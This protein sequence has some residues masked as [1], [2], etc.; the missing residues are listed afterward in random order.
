MPSCQLLHAYS[1]GMITSLI[2]PRDAHWGACI[3]V[4]EGGHSG[5]VSAVAASPRGHWIT[6]GSFDHGVRTWNAESGD[7]HNAM[8]DHSGDVTSLCI[9]PDSRF[10]A[11]GSQNGEIYVWNVATG[12]PIHELHRSS[13][14]VQITSVRAVTYSPDAGTIAAGSQFIR[15]IYANCVNSVAYSGDGSRLVVGTSEGTLCM[16]GTTYSSDGKTFDG[17]IGDVWTVVF[18][19]D[20]RTAAS[21]SADWTI[22]LWNTD[23]AECVRVL[24][25]HTGEVNS[26]CVSA[27]SNIIASGSTDCTVRLWDAQSGEALNVLQNHTNWVFSVAF[28]HDGTRLLSGSSDNTV[29]I[30]DLQALSA[31]PESMGHSSAVRCVALSDDLKYV[32]SCGEDGAIILWD[33]RRPKALQRKVDCAQGIIYRVAF[34]PDGTM[35]AAGSHSSINIWYLPDFTLRTTIKIK[36]KG[37]EWVDKLAFS[38]DSSKVYADFDSGTHPAIWSCETG[39]LLEYESND[40]DKRAIRFREDNGWITDRQTEKKLCWIADSKRRTFYSSPAETSRGCYYA[41]G[42]LTGKVTVLDLSA[43]V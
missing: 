8:F 12:A 21:G 5:A 11:S 13:D 19:Q 37:K 4:I 10:I 43:L 31:G 42:S 34:S 39:E 32:A 18:L 35:L 23:T 33:I 14:N 25:G 3:R 17:H 7:L 38:P 9:S 20:D 40:W 22:R 28:S 27:E 24:E 16:W 36:L 30:W 2:T 41:C 26:L 15:T 1:Q 29:R 6:S